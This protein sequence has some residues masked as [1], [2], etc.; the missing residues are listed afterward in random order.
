M[1]RP[2][3]DSETARKDAE[4]L[5]LL[6][7]FYYV[8]GAISAFFSLIPVIHL[9]VGL[10]MIAGGLTSGNDE[11]LLLSFMGVFFVI[12]AVVVITL[13]LT[14]AGGQL[15]T[16][17]CLARREK[18]VFCMVVAGISCMSFPMGTALGV[19]TFIVLARPS[20][21]ALFGPGGADPLRLEVDELFRAV[22]DSRAEA[23]AG[24]LLRLAELCRGPERAAVAYYAFRPERSGTVLSH[25]W[26]CRV[27]ARAAPN[28]IEM[29][30]GPLAAPAEE[31]LRAV[32]GRSPAG[33]GRESWQKWWDETGRALFENAGAGGDDVIR[34]CPPECPTCR[35]LERPGG[36]AAR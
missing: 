16:G 33:S 20:V 19:F 36:S 8:L 11:A 3:T 10:A 23:G 2:N 31:L 21:K 35:A 12:M 22:A 29:M 32:Q 24:A 5:R 28:I 30:D 14:I 27:L 13:G 4:H 18:Y 17:R 1:S 25:R 26:G 34:P 9:L 6:V 15:Y 7:T